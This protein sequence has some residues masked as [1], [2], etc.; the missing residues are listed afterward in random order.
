MLPSVTDFLTLLALLLG[1][2]IAGGALIK[3]IRYPPVVGFIL[4][5][6]AIGPFGFKF[7]KDLELVNLLAEFGIVIL[8]FVVGLEFSFGKLREVGSTALIVGLI[9]QS[10]MFFIG[11]IIGYLVGWNTTESLYL[12]GILAISSTAITLKLL[13]DAGIMQTKEAGTVIGTL[14][15]EDL[16]AILILVILSNIVKSGTAGVLEV[17]MTAA[18]TIGF[19]VITLAVGLKVVPKIIDAVDRLDIDEAPFLTALA[20]GF[21]LALLANYLGLSTAIGAFLMGMMIASAPKAEAITNKMLPLRDFFG[22]IFFVSIG[23][24]INIS[25]FPEYAWVSLP[26]IIVAIAGKLIGNFLGAFLSGHNRESATTIGI[27]M[28][29]R[30]E[31]S[32]II[33]KQGVDL[34][35]VREA[36]F[37]VTMIVSFASMVVIP[38]LMRALPTIMDSRTIMSPRFFVPL[39]ILGMIF[40][41][42]I[43]SL[44]QKERVS[45]VVKNMLPRILV[46]IAII[47]ALLSILS[48][49]DFYLT[50]VYQRLS[51]H[52]VPYEAFKLI[53]AVAVIAYPV[54]SIFGKAG[55]ITRLL[56]EET[57][58]RIKARSPISKWET[59][60]LHR[61]IRNI[62]VGMVLL[63]M[64]SFIT[65]SI[66]VITGIALIL[67]ISSFATLGI[68]VFLILDTFLVINRK[69]E[70]GIIR[71]LLNRDVDAKSEEQS[72]S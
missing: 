20:L 42:L 2:A 56:F 15:I 9:E 12:A 45:R 34:H 14:I 8:L 66:A 17:A 52:V 36:I 50:E 67:P 22:T 58:D 46:N 40:R 4:I 38:A 27:L 6:I 51:L 61:I 28:V 53:L 1:G 54:L 64:S 44:Q 43:L 30:G 55:E 33:A 18:Q 11:F 16:T 48:Q 21:G 60:Y 69:M 19:F 31:F 62:V 39:E 10:I 63:L 25:L 37:P 49:I 26:I 71:S 3:R 41:N 72:K 32:F 65:P 5:G 35:A 29:P 13:K 59:H 68:F 57:S 70:S 7:V 47:A 24:L 23:M